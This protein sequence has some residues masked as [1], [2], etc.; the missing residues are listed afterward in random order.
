MKQFFSI[1]L[2]VLL[3][4]SGCGN[5]NG[6][7]ERSS[8][9]LSGIVNEQLLK[10]VADPKSSESVI[11]IPVLYVDS[12]SGSDSN[13]GTQS[14]PFKTI[15]KATLVATASGIKVIAVAPGTYDA[16]LGEVF[17]IYIPEGVNLYG[18]SNGKGLAG[19]SSS[20]YAGPPGTSPKIGP[21]LISG[22]GS[23]PPTIYLPTVVPESGSQIAGFKINNPR[24]YDS[25]TV[26]A[27]IY[28]K[29]TGITVKNNTVTAVRGT[30]V[31][32]HPSN[33]IGGGHVISG[34]FITSNSHGLHEAD[35][36]SNSLVE[37]NLIA[38]NWIG[39][40]T[41]NGLLDLGG[42]SRGSKGRNTLSCNIM[43][44]L[45]V[46]VSQGFHFYALNNFWDHIPLTI[47]TFPDGS[48]T[49]DLEN[50]N[51]YAIVHLSGSSVV[52][53]PCNP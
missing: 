30:G 17:P 50:Y 51:Q 1:W 22:V 8:Q 24:F 39:I 35:S 3:L 41:F 20:L 42:G 4:F 10:I 46:D 13:A 23:F 37:D 31:S 52:S 48:V 14:A 44:D 38:Q 15:T 53:K 9:L 19:G 40:S 21:T 43:Y 45:E 12:I 27:G 49:A 36:N 34:N 28:L 26:N 47:A 6:G 32:I 29:N 5:E 7:N 16:S 11:I 2:A 18:D 25:S 33:G